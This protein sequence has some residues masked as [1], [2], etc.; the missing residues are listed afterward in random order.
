VINLELFS[1]HKLV[2][3]QDGYDLILYLNQNETEFSSELGACPE[4]SGS[5]QNSI[6][7]YMKDNLPNVKV[8]TIKVMMGTMMAS[9]FTFTGIQA[10]AAPIEP[11]K[12]NK[13][14]NLITYA[15][16]EGN[17][18]Y[19]IAKK[20]GLT[21]EQIKQMNNLTTN[22][23]KV[24]QVLTI[25]IE[26]ATIPISTEQAGKEITYTIVA[27]DNLWRIANRFGISVDEIKQANN[28]QT[29]LLTIGQKLTIPN[30]KTNQPTEVHKASYTVIKGDTLWA[31]AKKFNVSVDQLKGSNG[32]TT[33][34]LSVGQQLIIPDIST[35][36][37]QVTTNPTSPVMI[38]YTVIA[39][40][41]LSVISKKYNVPVDTI[42]KVNNLTTD[43]IKIGQILKVPTNETQTRVSN[44]ETK[45]VT[46]LTQSQL[47]TLGYDV[48]Q[49]STGSGV[50]NAIKS[51]QVDYGLP[52]TGVADIGTKTEIEHALVKKK[53]IPDTLKYLGVPYVWGGTTPSGFDCSGFVYYMFNQHDVHMARSTSESLFKTG[54]T[55]DRSRLQPGD[56][57][58]FGINTPGK[59]SHVGFYMGDHNFISATSSKGI[60]VYSIVDSYWSKY[61]LGAI[62]VY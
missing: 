8:K 27:G 17:T 18:L 48:V 38:S 37:Q 41:S 25:H 16:Q 11:I 50:V 56:L 10:Q 32:L 31:I 24:G 40:D 42:R 47:K 30:G 15:V 20:F 34:I 12:D 26:A 5:W 35:A 51:F 29:D 55:I 45:P 28:L 59:V 19:G 23:I 49:A 52:V 22:I 57:V 46:D 1:K 4:S 6:Q 61:Y 9:A 60:A 2:K 44:T 13:E 62:R 54:K 3:N 7:K 39:G 33:N 14:D 53:L 43:V 21:V 58:F 36:T